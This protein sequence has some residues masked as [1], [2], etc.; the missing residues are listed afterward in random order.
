MHGR[1]LLGPRGIARA[2]LSALVFAG[3]CVALDTRPAGAAPEG[4]F[5]M[6]PSNVYLDAGES[7]S[8]TIVL[9]GGQDV[10]EVYFALSY[11]DAI[12]QVADADAGQSGTQI[13]RGPFP[14]SVTPGTMLQNNGASGIITY[15]YELPGNATDAGS[16]TVATV[17]FT[18]LANGSAEFAWETLQI[19]DED[20]VPVQANGTVAT[21]VV[22]GVSPTPGAASATPSPTETAA[23]SATAEPATATASATATATAATA[24]PTGTRTATP[25]GSAT[26]ATATSTPGTPSAT[27]T[28]PQGQPPA[29]AID[30]ASSGP[31]G[32]LP[33]AGDGG[34]TTQ[35]WRWVFFGMALM[36][37]IAG[38]FFTLAVYNGSREVILVD[39]S[40]R[41]KRRR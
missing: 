39:R 35:W 17:L 33:S 31:A 20:G 26:A 25:T 8:V 28:T 11:D 34:A 5:A 30:P 27:A 22:G 4:S 36:F 9:N 19:V 40:D 6:S 14:D 7:I 15:Q 38:W 41:R 3:L 32:A 1:S 29:A 12:V 16:G 23:P 37:G 18:A 24:T 10:H 21:L 13:L 2:L